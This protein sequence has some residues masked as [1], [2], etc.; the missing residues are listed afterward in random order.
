MA[1]LPHEVPRNPRAVVYGGLGF[2]FR[3]LWLRRFVRTSGL[4]T[5]SHVTTLRVQVASLLEAPKSPCVYLGRWENF[6][7]RE[8]SA[9]IVLSSKRLLLRTSRGDLS[10]RHFCQNLQDFALA[11]K[12]LVRSSQLIVGHRG[13]PL[14]MT[15]TTTQRRLL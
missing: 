6:E 10:P 2:G 1:H 4:Q 9:E 7:R 3:F 12:G 8:K 13:V 5:V 15:R 11:Q 14:L